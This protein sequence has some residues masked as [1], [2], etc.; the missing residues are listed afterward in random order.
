EAVGQDLQKKLTDLHAQAKGLAKVDPGTQVE[1]ARVETELW[2]QQQL[3]RKFREAA[4]TASAKLIYLLGLHPGAE[5][6]VLD[7]QIVG[8]DLVDV[9]L[10]ATVLVQHA[11][12]HGPGIREVEGL[13]NLLE[14]TRQQ[15]GGPGRFLPAFE[16]TMLEGGFAA[17]PGDRA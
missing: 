12:A 13:L 14:N 5:L 7:K 11:L 15:L 8:F 4:N 16:V 6:V 17:G 3:T 10:P 9:D 2:G 1:V